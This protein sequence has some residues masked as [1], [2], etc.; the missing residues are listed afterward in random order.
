MGRLTPGATYIYESPDGGE[1]VYARESGSTERIMIG[2]STRAKSLIKEIRENEL[3]VDIRQ[4]AETNP[5]LQE[6]LERAKIIYHLSKENGN[7]KT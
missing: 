4:M 7:S 5:T 1:T 6:A 3:W 2:Q